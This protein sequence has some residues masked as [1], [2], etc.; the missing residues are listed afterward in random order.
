[1][2]TPWPAVPLGECCDVLPGF[3]FDSTH[4]ANEGSMP[5]VRIRDVVR[6]TTDTYYNGKFDEKYLVDNGDLL[7]GMD[8]QFNRARWQGGPALLNQRVCKVT[9]RTDVMNSDFLFYCLPIA[10]KAIEDETPYVTVKHLSVPKL[11]SAAL[12]YPPIED[13]R[14]IASILD[15]A[16]EVRAKRRA[17]V[18]TLRTVREAI[19]VKLFGDPVTNPM[20]W[21]EKPELGDIADITSGITKGRVIK[22]MDYKV[23]SVPYL[24]VSNVQD[25][26]LNLDVV[27]EIEATDHEIEKFKLFSDDLLLTEGG[28][29]DK[30]GRGTLWRSEIQECIHQN[31]IFR[32]RVRSEDFSPL[33]VS[34]LIGSERGK[35]Y[36]LRSA[37]QTTGIAS[38]NKTQLSKFRLLRPPIS[39]QEDLPDRWRLSNPLG[40]H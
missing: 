25:G 36:F 11:K 30:L 37:K 17:T 2:T 6:G 18:E 14:R 24:A 26:H 32:V 4:F 31:H 33:F 19:F 10:L 38:I 40:N 20:R 5:L 34:R 12:P 9:S 13:Q 16:D 8:G 28:D 7:V 27:K 29:P 39:L 21:P 15:K 3:A 22:K 35:R 23:R 1:M